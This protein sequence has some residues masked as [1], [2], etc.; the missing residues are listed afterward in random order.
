VAS[1]V[2]AVRTVLGSGRIDAFYDAHELKPG[3]DWDRALLDGA[4][5]SALLALRTDLYAS[6]EWCQ[7]EM[8]TAKVHGMPVVVVD[9]LSSGESRG[10]FL[11]DHTPRIPARCDSNGEWGLDAIRRAI[12]LLA[13]A[14]LHRVLW[15][16]LQAQAR[17]RAGLDRWWWAPQAPEPS[18]LARWLSPPVADADPS[19]AAIAL[20]DAGEAVARASAAPRMPARQPGSELCI[21]HPD[22]PLAADERSVLQHLV[23][24][25]GYGQ[26]DLATPRLLASRGA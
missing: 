9:A 17:G 23:A 2:Q 10:S 25:A 5:G 15:L 3:A 22:P 12:N 8:L 11:M 19:A 4:A 1:L 26:L 14:W 21:L 7:R 24:L 20:A 6:R 13:D 18:T 16:R